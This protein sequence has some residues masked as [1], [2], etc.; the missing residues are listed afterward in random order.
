M[1]ASLVGPVIGLLDKFIP[2]VNERAK[3]AQEIATLAA[4]QAHELSM[5]QIDL[6]K[7]EAGSDSLFKGGWRP[8]IG[9]IC[10]SAFAY[11]FIAQP[12][13]I[14]FYTMISGHPPPLPTLDIASLMTILGGMLGLGGMRTFE[15]YTNTTG[16]K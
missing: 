3:L 7:T 12:L 2:D 6:D 10:G 15:K 1:F 5:A 4:R 14:F 11:N 9:W 8:F 16:N 13:L